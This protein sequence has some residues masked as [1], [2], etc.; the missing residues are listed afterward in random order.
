MLFDSKNANK[1]EEHIYI[2]NFSK[3][4]IVKKVD[5]RIENGQKKVPFSEN[6]K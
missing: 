1:K 6:Q 2:F 3:E 4:K 5:A